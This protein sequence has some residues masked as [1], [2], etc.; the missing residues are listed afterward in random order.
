[1]QLTTTRWVTVAATSST[2]PSPQS[3]RAARAVAISSGKRA[4]P[5]VSLAETVSVGTQDRAEFEALLKKALA[6][7]PDAAPQLRLANT[8]AQRRASWLLA[9]ADQLF[10]E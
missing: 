5:Y 10:L 6:V 1:M 7:D 4:A 2:G 8:V 3:A 9:R